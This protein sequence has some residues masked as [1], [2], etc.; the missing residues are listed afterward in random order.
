MLVF[1]LIVE[2]NYMLSVSKIDVDVEQ[3]KERTVSMS[4]RVRGRTRWTVRSRRSLR[5]HSRQ[6]R[7]SYDFIHRD[8]QT[9]HL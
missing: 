8:P 9:R 5:L 6:I 3:G 4:P 7:R 2:S 1:L